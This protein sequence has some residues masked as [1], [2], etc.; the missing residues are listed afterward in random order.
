MTQP[1]GWGRLPVSTVIPY[2]KAIK[3]LIDQ[4]SAT[5]H[6]THTKYK[7]YSVTVHHNGGRQS[8]EG[9]LATWQT[10]PASAHFDVDAYGR[11]AQYVDVHE[12][13]WAAGS[14][15]GNVE[16]IHIEH[17]NSTLG[18]DWQ[19]APE[20]W[21]EGARLAGWLHAY[22]LEGRPRPS[23][24]T[25]KPHHDWYNT[26]CCGPFLDSIFNQY[27]ASA[28]AAYD[29]FVRSNQPEVTGPVAT[30]QQ[31]LRAT[32]DGHWGPATDM[33]AMGMRNAASLT[34][35]GIKVGD[36]NVQAVQNILGTQQTPLWKN[37]DQTKMGDWVGIVQGAVLN[38]KPD[39]VWGPIT[40][41][42]F[43]DLRARSL[44]K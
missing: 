32:E 9:V 8:H 5:G 26:M 10:R 2:D 13:A 37:E 17:C 44:N 31:A 40:D 41:K 23:R 24:A 42:A 43:M 39:K 38:V 34:T 20:T 14:T 22:V 21:H 30:L 19:V 35:A 12:Y 36:F 16:S 4:L 11:V 29:V 27:I 25:V 28:Q 1:G 33:G 18:P 3:N 6:V 15:Q 7:K